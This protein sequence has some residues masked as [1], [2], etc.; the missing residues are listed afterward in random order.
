MKRVHP[1]MEA[2]VAVIGSGPAGL[3]AAIALVSNGVKATVF[4]RLSESGKEMYIFI[5]PTKIIS[6]NRPCQS[7][8][9]AS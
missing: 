2:D 4:D 3:S 5:T 8:K 6:Q 9:S 1:P 7:D